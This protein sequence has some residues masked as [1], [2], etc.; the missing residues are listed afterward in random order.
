MQHPEPAVEVYVTKGTITLNGTGA[1]VAPAID[2]FADGLALEGANAINA[3]FLYPP[4]LESEAPCKPKGQP[5]PS[6]PGLRREPRWH[7]GI[8]GPTL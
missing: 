3:S 4:M 7:G 6:V 5:H 8:G 2:I 1:I